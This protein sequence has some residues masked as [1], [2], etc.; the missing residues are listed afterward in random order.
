MVELRLNMYCSGESS[1]ELK[2]KSPKDVAGKENV[3][4]VNPIWA[5]V[6]IVYKIPYMLISTFNIH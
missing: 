1:T 2:S 3:A 5:Y 4:Y 6:Y